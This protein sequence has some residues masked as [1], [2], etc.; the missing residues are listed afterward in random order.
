MIII[1]IQNHWYRLNRLSFYVNAALRARYLRECRACDITILR[2]KSLCVLETVLTQRF[3]S[4]SLALL[5]WTLAPFAGRRDGPTDGN[6]SNISR[7]DESH[8]FASLAH[9]PLCMDLRCKNST[10][11]FIFIIRKASRLL[12]FRSQTCCDHSS[13][14]FSVRFVSRWRRLRGTGI[15]IFFIY[16][17]SLL[18]HSRT[19][20]SIDYPELRTHRSR[21]VQP[22]TTRLLPN[23]TFRVLLLR[24]RWYALG[25]VRSLNI[26][27]RKWLAFS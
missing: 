8:L 14:F 11:R 27:N 2:S 17:S 13:S 19:C 16:F 3:G 9:D 6:A 18:S 20:T 4:L 23:G 22:R 26:C 10:H 12:K 21:V 25:S 24:K 7:D 5:A 15:S 1:I